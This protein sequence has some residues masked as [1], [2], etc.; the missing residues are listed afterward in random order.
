M[1]PSAVAVYDVAKL[2]DFGMVKPIDKFES[3]ELTHDG[4]ITGSPLFMSPE[5]ATGDSEPDERSD[6]Y[7]LGVV[8]Y[9]LLTGRPP[10]EGTQPIKI[11]VAHAHKTAGRRCRRLH[12]TF[13]PISRQS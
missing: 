13:P 8:A 10:F 7:S 9:Y 2:L 1:P 4:S 5:Q 11:L 3:P 12:L 6:I